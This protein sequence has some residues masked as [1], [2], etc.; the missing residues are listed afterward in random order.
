MKAFVYGFDEK[1]LEEIQ[2]IFGNITYID[3]TNQYQDILACCADIVLINVQKCDYSVLCTIKDFED[4]VQES[5]TRYF[6]FCGDKLDVWSKEER[7]LF[8]RAFDFASFAHRGTNR[9]GTELPFM[10]HPTEAAMIV[11]GMTDSVEIIAASLLHDVVEDTEYSVENIGQRFGAQI[12]GLV[13]EESEDKRENL[14]ADESWKI[15]KEEFLEKLAKATIEAKKITLGDKLSNMRA[16]HRDYREFGDEIWKRFNQKDKQEQG[17]YYR[18]IASLLD[19]LNGY[20]AWK[21]YQ[22]LCSE[23]FG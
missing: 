2:R 11:S 18:T 17:W 6:Y 15:R 12:A 23:V 8:G 10:V 21:E 16:L 5:E 1:Q 22:L 9:K 7:E 20:D 13:C 14:P 3:V 4:E 19:E